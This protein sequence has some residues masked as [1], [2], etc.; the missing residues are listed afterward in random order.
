MK[1]GLDASNTEVANN[2]LA[3]TLMQRSN[4]LIKTIVE[5]T[6]KGWPRLRVLALGDLERALKVDPKLAQADLLVARLQALPG[7]DHAAAV[8]AAE[9]AAELSKD[10]AETQ[11]EVLVLLAGL[12][13]D[14]DKK[15]DYFGQA[16][17]IAPNNQEALRER[18]VFLLLS[19]KSEEAV[20]DLEGA[21][22]ADPDNPDAHEILGLAQFML[23]C[24][25]DAVKSFS[26]A[27]R[28]SPD[29]ALRISAAPRC[30]GR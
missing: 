6:P 30:T 2:L 21:V 1:K 22:K 7:G 24:P 17:K 29:S 18:G 12:T 8:K 5:R 20:K 27:I 16:L 14:H 15:L 11:V 19:G 23:K 25:D 3:G 10:N 4:F 13:E 9:Q 28:L 26:E